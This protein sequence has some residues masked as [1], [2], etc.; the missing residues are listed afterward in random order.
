MFKKLMD[1]KD[2]YSELIAKQLQRIIKRHYS[3]FLKQKPGEYKKYELKLARD[4]RYEI[5]AYLRDSMV[6]FLE[7]AIPGMRIKTQEKILNIKGTDLISKFSEYFPQREFPVIVTRNKKIIVPEIEK[8]IDV[9]YLSAPA[10][11]VLHCLIEI[12][13]ADSKIRPESEFE[14]KVRSIFTKNEAEKII[15]SINRCGGVKNVQ[16]LVAETSVRYEKAFLS[17]KP[18]DA[19]IFHYHHEKNSDKPS[20]I[21]EVFTSNFIYKKENKYIMKII[22]KKTPMKLNIGE[23][24][25]VY[26]NGNSIQMYAG[27]KKALFMLEMTNPFTKKIYEYLDLYF[28][29]YEPLG[30]YAEHDDYTINPTRTLVVLQ[31]KHN[32]EDIRVIRMDCEDQKHNYPHIN[33]KLVAINTLNR[34]YFERVL[35]KDYEGN[36]LDHYKIAEKTSKTSFYYDEINIKAKEY[37][38]DVIEQYGYVD[39]LFTKGYGYFL[40]PSVLENINKAIKDFYKYNT[41][42]KRI[43]I[44]TCLLNYDETEIVKSME[45]YLKILN[46]YLEKIRFQLNKQDDYKIPME[47]LDQREIDLNNLKDNLTQLT[48]I[49]ETEKDFVELLEDRTYLREIK[50]KDLDDETPLVQKIFNKYSINVNE[51]DGYEKLTKKLAAELDN[52]K[53]NLY[54]KYKAIYLSLTEKE[55]IKL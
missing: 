38:I 33:M 53:Q 55:I 50:I 8:V 22:N 1:Y 14:E 36:N 19:Q 51:E 16:A 30:F 3:D 6:D 2:K 41:S 54:N 39:S 29:D 28:Y 42:K 4:Y 44:H 10:Q 31:N 13:Q 23:G 15:K 7:F 49:V 12:V 11:F 37:S 43:E 27:Y 32:I 48:A 26:I 18:D 40:V 5:S 17:R 21:D 34:L 24:G 45:H 35:L 46:A 47:K 9:N 25:D 20:L 52:K